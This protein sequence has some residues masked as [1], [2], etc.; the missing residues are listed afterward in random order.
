M[1]AGGC[2]A[3]AVLSA[4]VDPRRKKRKKKRKKKMD[5]PRGRREKHLT[6]RRISDVARRRV[7]ACT[8]GGGRKGEKTA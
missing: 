7:A 6:A 5:S 3:P 2:W 1:R 4:T 8:K